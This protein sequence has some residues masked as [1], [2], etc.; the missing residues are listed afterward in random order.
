M[1]GAHLV[2]GDYRWG[3]NPL[4]DFPSEDSPAT[5]RWGRGRHKKSEMRCTL[6]KSVASARNKFW[7]ILTPTEKDE[8]YRNSL[9]NQSQ[10]TPNPPSDKENSSLDE[11]LD[12]F[13]QEDGELPDLP[14]FPATNEFASDSEQVEKNIDIAEEKEEVPMNDI[15]MDENHEIDHSGTEEA[16]QWRLAKD[17][18]LV[19]MEINDQSSFLLHTIPLF[20]SNEVLS[21]REWNSSMWSNASLAAGNHFKTGLVGYHVDDNVGTICDDGCCS[22]KQTWSTA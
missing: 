19:I 11:I 15:K 21:T 7:Y 10:H 13:D 14:T 9:S 16:L 17:L 5:F 1:C 8:E 22:R 18:L 2:A 4:R 6:K 20:I 12:D 3:K